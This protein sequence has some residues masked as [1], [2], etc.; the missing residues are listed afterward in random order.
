MCVCVENLN[1]L[2]TEAQTNPLVKHWG[3]LLGDVLINTPVC[4]ASRSCVSRPRA[5]SRF[6]FFN[7]VYFRISSLTFGA[8]PNRQTHK[9]PTLLTRMSKEHVCIVHF[10]SCQFTES[11]PTFLITILK[12][13]WSESLRR[14]FY[15]N[16]EQSELA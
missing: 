4:R 15:S 3:L 1:V 10:G 8:A 6:F 2:R 5:P 7:S 16:S 14:R 13:D 9:Y 11:L 12:S